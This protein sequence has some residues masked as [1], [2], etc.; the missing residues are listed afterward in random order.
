LT[1]EQQDKYASK[2]GT[3][4]RYLRTH[5]FVKQ[6]RRKIPRKPMIDGLVA[7]TKGRCSLDDVLEYLYKE[8]NAKAA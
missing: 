4:G 6:E 2:A 5:I 3:T 1:E 8:E 7:A